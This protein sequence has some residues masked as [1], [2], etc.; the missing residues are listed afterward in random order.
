[1]LCLENL[2]PFIIESELRLRNKGILESSTVAQNVYD[3]T[4][5]IVKHEELE[6]HKECVKIKNNVQTSFFPNK[7][8]WSWIVFILMICTVL[9][10][11]MFRIV[12]ELSFLSCIYE[13]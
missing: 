4:E 6:E 10:Y 5:K 8:H 3:Q 9:I 2:L 11:M 1:L 7:I 12:S 13:F